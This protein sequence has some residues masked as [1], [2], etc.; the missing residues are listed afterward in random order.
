MLTRR[1]E[2]TRKGCQQR[3]QSGTVHG[4]RRKTK[5]VQGSGREEC[6]KESVSVILLV[7]PQ[8]SNFGL[9]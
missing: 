2:W 8:T 1:A 9:T 3:R 7:W 4:G 6:C 5:R